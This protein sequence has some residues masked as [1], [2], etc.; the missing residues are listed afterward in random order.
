MTPTKLSLL[1]VLSAHAHDTFR[2]KATLGRMLTD[3]SRWHDILNPRKS[4]LYLGGSIVL[5]ILLTR[6]FI[7]V[8]RR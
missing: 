7:G 5:G 3:S 1:R 4:T 8:L 2:G 6:L